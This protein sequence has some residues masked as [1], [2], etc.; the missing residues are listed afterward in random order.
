MPPSTAVDSWIRG[1]DT[2]RT[3]AATS[4]A[5]GPVEIQARFSIAA[6]FAVAA[7]T[8]AAKVRT[9]SAPAGTVPSSQRSAGPDCAGSGA[10][11]P[12]TYSRSIPTVS[13]TAVFGASMPL[14][15]SVMLYTRVSPGTTDPPLRSVTA[16][17]DPLKERM[18]LHSLATA[19]ATDAG[20]SC[21]G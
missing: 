1:S 20:S 3:A 7:G 11:D 8:R 2:T 16:S 15:L 21:G 18:M 14:F 13:R 9:C 19:A 5:V 12:G 17:C 10:A 6:W 4:W